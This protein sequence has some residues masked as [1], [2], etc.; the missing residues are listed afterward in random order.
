MYN[1]NNPGPE[2]DHSAVFELEPPT[3]GSGRYVTPDA[4]P[5]GPVVPSWSYTAP[6]KT[7]FHSGFISGARRLPDGHTLIT[8]GAQGRFFEVTPDGDIVWEYWTPYS[9]NVRM[10]DGSTPH[11]VGEDTYAVFR[12]TKISPDHPAVAGRD[13][14]PLDPQPAI[15]TP[16]R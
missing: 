12:A 13:L 15:V 16:A 14:A 10:P 11:P 7:S 1:N 2:G 8:S 5:Y 9:G 6:D 3:E 4:G